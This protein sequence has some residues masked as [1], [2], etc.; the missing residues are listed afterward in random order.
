MYGDNPSEVGTI[1]CILLF[2]IATIAT[3]AQ[4]IRK[5]KDAPNPIGVAFLF[6]GTP[7]L[8]LVGYTLRLPSVLEPSNP[9]LYL[10]NMIIIGLGPL[11]LAAVSWF[12]FPALLIFAGIRYAVVRPRII[13]V[14]A[15]ILLVSCI[16]LQVR[17]ILKTI[18]SLKTGLSQAYNYTEDQGFRNAGSGLMLGGLGLVLGLWIVYAI[19]FALFLRRYFGEHSLKATN[20]VSGRVRVITLVLLINIVTV[21]VIL[22]SCIRMG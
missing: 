14:Q 18:S 13:A 15:C 21:L 6:L 2:F 16:Q 4:V 1:V 8:E 7:I 9:G 20:S 19:L 11:Y 10:A 5:R 12:V 17:G 3:L 22:I